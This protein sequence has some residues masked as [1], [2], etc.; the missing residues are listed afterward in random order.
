MIAI[1]KEGGDYKLKYITFDIKN[2]DED[3]NYEF[4]NE[5]Y[6]TYQKSNFLGFFQ[7]DSYN[8]YFIDYNSYEYVTGYYNKNEEINNE[9]IVN[10]DIQTSYKSPF[11]FYDSIE[12]QEIKFI[13][14]NK[15]VYYKIKNNN[16]N[17]I[18]HGIIDVSL[19]KV[20]F[21]TDKEIS[22][23]KPFSYSSMLAITKDSAYQ[24]CI[25]KDG[26]NC[27]ESCPNNQVF[28]A[29]SYN[30]CGDKCNDNQ[31]ILKPN[32]ICIDT[33][34]TSIYVIKDNNQCWLCKDLNNQFKLVNYSE[35]LTSMPENSYYVNQNLNIIACN[36]GL[37]FENGQ[38]ISGQCNEN[39]KECI[40]YSSDNNNQKCK[41]CKNSNFFLQEGNCV[42]KCSSEYFL[43]E[44]TC[45]KCDISCKSC[46]KN[47]KNCTYCNEGYY[48]N[49]NSDSNNCEKCSIDCKTCSKGEEGDIKN[50]DSCYQNS[51]LKYLY[52]KTC[53]KEC[54]EN[55]TIIE[56]NICTF[57]KEGD[58]EEEREHKD[59]I[60]LAIF[61]VV[62][63][64]L[65]L[66]IIFCFFK[67]FCWNKNKPNDRLID[68]INNNTTE[69]LNNK[70]M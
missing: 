7:K 69:L 5:H 9:N 41:S 10:I 15:Y 64:T 62:T 29:S 66:I 24:I 23:F 25:L 17:I 44:K 43:N 11:Q 18:Y 33:C 12:I 28:D 4:K 37:K 13:Y 59:D 34:D 63:G 6:L 60:M 45:E 35:C 56:Q 38:C 67:K 65:L 53:L 36:K 14:E 22:E 47:S 2:N 21:N 30:H 46:F 68:E 27:I 42:E 31:Y 40:E 19:N 1:I 55:A 49:K 58:E 70:E 48:L 51:S 20:I 26:N 50:C 52:N 3:F 8:F 32:D 16:K 54:P 57:K 39:C 61:I